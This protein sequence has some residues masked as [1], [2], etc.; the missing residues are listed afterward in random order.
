MKLS[1]EVFAI[2]L[3]ILTK[4]Q[5]DELYDRIQQLN[6]QPEEKEPELQPVIREEEPYV[7]PNDFSINH[8]STLAGKSGGQKVKAGENQWR[9]KGEEKDDFDKVVKRKSKVPR[10]RPKTQLK[11]MVCSVCHRKNMVH[12]SIIGG[13]YYRCENCVG[14]G[15]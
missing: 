12:P 9:D 4:E 7:N 14:G 11:E 6:N 5:V 10:N 2:V 3:D 8:N 1:K 13:S 15:V